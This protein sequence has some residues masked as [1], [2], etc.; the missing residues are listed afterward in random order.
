MVWS[1]TREAAEVPGAG[2]A[3]ALAAGRES[4]RAGRF[5]EAGGAWEAAWRAEH[6]EAR[7]LLHALVYLAAA[8]VKA[9]L[10]RNPA[11][12]ARLLDGALALLEKLP[13]RLGDVDVGLLRLD[14]RTARD[15]A[16]GWR[17][18]APLPDLAAPRI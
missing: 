6:G 12:A 11:G 8:M 2:S 1:A 15:R 10:H 7:T 4:Y 18:S 9:R 16:A 5:R 17:P 13:R 14:V 3:E